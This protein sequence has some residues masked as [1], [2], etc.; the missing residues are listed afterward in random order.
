MSIDEVKTYINSEEVP[1]PP[2]FLNGVRWFLMNK[3][4]V[5]ISD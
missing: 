5:Y 4:N 2:T 3:T 1:G